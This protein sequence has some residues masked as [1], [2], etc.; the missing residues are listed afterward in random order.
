MYGDAVAEH[1]GTRVGCGF[2]SHCY[3]LCEDGAKADHVWQQRRFESRKLYFSML[4]PDEWPRRSHSH[5]SCPPRTTF[6]AL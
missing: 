6:E 2:G 1:K 4:L 5:D 3:S